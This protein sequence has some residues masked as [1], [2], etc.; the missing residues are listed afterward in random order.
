MSDTAYK[1]P[2]GA[3]TRS[4]CLS[5]LADKPRLASRIR[6]VPMGVRGGGTGGGCGRGARCG[7]ATYAPVRRATTGTARGAA[8]V[9]PAHDGISHGPLP[10][11]LLRRVSA[12]AWP[13]RAQQP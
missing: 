12:G 1:V 2:A 5:T 7:M 4:A 13:S 6:S 10:L 3:C 8:G 11:D 9:E